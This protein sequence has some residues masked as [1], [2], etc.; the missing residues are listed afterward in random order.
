MIERDIRTIKDGEPAQINVGI[1]VNGTEVTISVTGWETPDQ[2]LAALFLAG[3]P[4]TLRNLAEMID[5]DL[6]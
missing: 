2:A 3:K 6:A 1:D 5:E 4:E